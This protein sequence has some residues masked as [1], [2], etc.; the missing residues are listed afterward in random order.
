MGSYEYQIS[1][2]DDLLCPLG[3]SGREYY[4]ADECSR[5]ADCRYATALARLADSGKGG[6][7]AGLVRAC[8]N[9][10]G[11]AIIAPDSSHSNTAALAR[12][13]P[14]ASAAALASCSS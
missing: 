3:K 10:S 12:N 2:L 9:A 13:G 11:G 14:T 7:A 1:G 5:G 4:R 8:R 6:R